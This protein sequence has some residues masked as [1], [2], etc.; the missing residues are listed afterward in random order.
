MDR[1]N[2]LKNVAFGGAWSEQIAGNEAL[3]QALDHIAT[4]VQCSGDEDLE[5]DLELRMCLRVVA[6]V[7][8]KGGELMRAWDRALGLSNGGLRM[9]ELNRLSKLF[10]K[11]LEARLGGH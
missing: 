8:P 10:A 7:H 1:I 2:Q 5:A 6:K 3:R 4:A 9:A 11:G